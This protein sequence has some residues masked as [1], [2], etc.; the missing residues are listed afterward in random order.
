MTGS[1]PLPTAL[2]LAADST[3]TAR[4]PRIRAHDVSRTVRGRTVVDRVSLAAIPTAG[5][6]PTLGPAVYVRVG[7]AEGFKNKIENKKNKK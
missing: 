7:G 4:D 3:M 5:Q 6:L 2:S 1:V